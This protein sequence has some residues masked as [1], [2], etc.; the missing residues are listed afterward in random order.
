MTALGMW[1]CQWRELRPIAF[2][3]SPSS[4]QEG[5]SQEEQPNGVIGSLIRSVMGR[6]RK[7]EDRGEYEMVSRKEDSSEPV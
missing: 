4:A 5:S 3:G 1:A 7:A 2:G 6:G